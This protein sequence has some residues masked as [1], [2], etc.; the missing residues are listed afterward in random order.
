MALDAQC[1]RQTNESNIVLAEKGREICISN[2]TRI[3]HGVWRIDGCLRQNVIACDFAVG[4]AQQGSVYVELKGKDVGH[5]IEQLMAS[6]DVFKDAFA[7][8][9]PSCFV[10]V[11]RQYPRFPEALRKFISWAARNGGA[12]VHLFT[13]REVRALRDLLE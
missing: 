6:W 8:G 3:P 2:P 12:K 9:R 5:A 10:I 4:Q 13:K 11:C 7:P 1:C